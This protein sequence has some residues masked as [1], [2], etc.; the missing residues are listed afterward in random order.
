MPTR[1]LK[2]LCCSCCWFGGHLCSATQLAILEQQ[3]RLWGQHGLFVKVCDAVKKFPGGK[4]GE[5]AF[6]RDELRK[7]SSQLPTNT[8]LPFD[9]RVRLGELEIEECKVMGSAKRPL[10]LVFKNAD[11]LGSKIVLMFKSGDD[12]RQDTV[13]LQVGVVVLP[14]VHR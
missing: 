1:L 7:L 6:A 8:V 11:P 9:P 14:R 12:L 5:T 2:D 4:K 10:W 13:T 3:G